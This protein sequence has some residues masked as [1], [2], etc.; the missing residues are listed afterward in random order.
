VFR[1]CPKTN[2]AIRQFYYGGPNQKTHEAYMLSPSDLSR[3]HDRSHIFKIYA[4]RSDSGTK[5]TGP[6]VVISVCPLAL[7]HDRP[8]LL[9]PFLRCFY[10][11]K[12]RDR[13]DFDG[14]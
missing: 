10:V 11:C 4:G 13:R 3:D 2:V 5:L 14:E 1:R 6:S 12:D 9:S 7:R 8:K